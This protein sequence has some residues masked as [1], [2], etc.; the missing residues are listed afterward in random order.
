MIRVVSG[1][2]LVVYGLFLGGFA[3][4]KRKRRGETGKGFRDGVRGEGMARDVL[5]R[6]G[7]R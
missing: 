2:V 6:R 1:V 3:G 5:G 7:G 4:G